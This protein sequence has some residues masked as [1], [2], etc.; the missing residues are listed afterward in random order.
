MQLHATFINTRHRKGSRRIPFDATLLLRQYGATD[1]GRTPTPSLHVSSLHQPHVDGYYHCVES[2][3][4]MAPESVHEQQ[5]ASVGDRLA[6]E[7]LVPTS[8][9]PLTPTADGVHSATTEVRDTDEAERP[10]KAQMS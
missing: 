1:L 5:P 8:A 6:A 2:V 7:P 10:L 9:E 4:L 3:S